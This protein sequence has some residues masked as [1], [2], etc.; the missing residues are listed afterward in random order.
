MIV[1]SLILIN[2]CLI[3]IGPGIFEYSISIAN[4]YYFSANILNYL[5][6]AKFIFRQLYLLHPK[7][8]F[9]KSLLID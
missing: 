5:I 3:L 8:L 2:Y 7:I 1:T 6:I 9:L 4:L